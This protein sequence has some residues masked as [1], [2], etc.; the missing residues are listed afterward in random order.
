MIVVSMPPR[1]AKVKEGAQNRG[2]LLVSDEQLAEFTQT[3]DVTDCETVCV[4]VGEHLRRRGF[5][6]AMPGSKP[7]NWMERR[8]VHD[9]VSQE[10][11]LSEIRGE[12]ERARFESDYC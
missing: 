3:H 10:L 5:R 6:Y 7:F 8:V 4:M 1:P 9:I 2:A 12:I 11:D